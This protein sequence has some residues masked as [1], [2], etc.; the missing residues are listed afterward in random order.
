MTLHHGNASMRKQI[1][2]DGAVFMPLLLTVEEAARLLSVGRPKMWRLVMSGEVLSVKIGASRRIP[3][4]ALDD[5]IRQLLG[6]AGT[7]TYTIP[8]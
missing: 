6:E 5:Y 4:S 1:N 2:R 8:A 7:L 3:K